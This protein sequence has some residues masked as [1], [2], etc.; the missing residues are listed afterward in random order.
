ML[1][2]TLAASG[3]ADTALAPDNVVWAGVWTGEMSDASGPG[4]AR[5]TL[6]QSADRVTGSVTI[7]DADTSFRGRGSTSGTVAGRVFSFAIE[8][9]AGGFD[10]PHGG[11]SAVLSGAVTMSAATLVGMYSGTN[12]CTGPILSGR[13]ALVKQ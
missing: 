10:D 4:F 9:P 7:D 11:C 2:A 12:S 3:C 8:I 1:S 5:W 6:S 13:I